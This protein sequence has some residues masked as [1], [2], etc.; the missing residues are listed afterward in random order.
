MTTERICPEDGS[1]MVRDIRPKTYHYKH[2]QITVDM[3]GWYC[4]TCGE[5]IHNG[6]D[7]KV[8]DRA[9]HLM[10]ARYETAA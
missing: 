1:V 7:M 4:T 8:S 3:P 5:S 10:K 9:L 2:Q 6:E